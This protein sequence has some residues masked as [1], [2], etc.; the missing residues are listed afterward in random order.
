META[1]R[2]VT[3]PRRRRAVLSSAAA[4]LGLLTLAPPSLEAGAPAS[5]VLHFS[6]L[7]SRAVAGQA[8]TVSVAHARANALCSLAVNYGTSSTQPGLAPK[9]AVNGGASWSWTIPRTIEADR[10]QLTAACTGSKHIT[11][12]FLVVGSLI[13]PRMSVVKDGFSIRT[14]TGGRTDVSYGVLIKNHSPNADALDVNVLVNFVLANN[15]LLGSS[16]N[17]IPLIAAGST[18]ALGNN[19]GF[20]GAAPVARLEIV[21]QV[22]SSNRHVGHAPAVDNVVIEPSTYEQGWVGDVAGE[23]INNDA[24]LMLESAQYSAV[25]FDSAGNVLG[26]G[27]GSG[28]GSPLPPGT[29]EVFKLTNGGFSD[30]PYEQAASAMVSAIPTWQTGT[31]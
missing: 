17:R 31:A 24:H 14:S 6:R 8:V 11:T 25:V 26:G 27:S 15:H 30:I 18:Y 22:G 2:R 1:S 19:L 7:P 29:R 28:Y 23:L 20:P 21:I 12:K 5:A 4:L 16:S 3:T 13:P 10:A 9:T